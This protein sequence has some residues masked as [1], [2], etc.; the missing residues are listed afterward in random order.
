MPHRGMRSVLFV[1]TCVVACS[2]ER[3][4]PRV[5]SGATPAPG[6]DDRGASCL[7]VSDVRACWG[8]PTEDETCRHGTCLLRRPLPDAPAPPSGFR[9]SGQRSERTCVTRAWNGA[10]FV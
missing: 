3:A 8:D 5:Q 4:T 7:D 10:P 6:T 1:A 9:C 2:A